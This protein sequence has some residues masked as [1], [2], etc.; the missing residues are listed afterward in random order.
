MVHY[1]RMPMDLRNHLET[2]GQ[3][4]KAEV[5]FEQPQKLAQVWH[6]KL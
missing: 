1:S 4:L 2:P 5:D 6:L 3:V